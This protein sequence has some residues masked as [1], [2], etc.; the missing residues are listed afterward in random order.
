MLIYRTMFKFLE[1]G[2]HA[3]VLDFP[4]VITCGPDLPEVRR[5]LASALVAMAKLRLE[6]GQ[7]LPAPNPLA[8]DPVADLTEPI[9]LSFTD[10]GQSLIS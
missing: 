10:N 9:H 5:L 6:Q 2:V 8:K 7:P 3:E 1:D 4:G